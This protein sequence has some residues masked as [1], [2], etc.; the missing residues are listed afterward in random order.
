MIISIILPICNNQT[1]TPNN[2]FINQLANYRVQVT[3][4]TPIIA[5]GSVVLINFPRQFSPYQFQIN[6][7]YS[8][9]AA[10]DSC[11]NAIG[12]CTAVT[13]DCSGQTIILNNLY[14]NPGT[15]A[16]TYTIFNIR[17]PLYKITTSSYTIEIRSPDYV[18][19]L[20]RQPVTGR[21]FFAEQFT[22]ITATLNN[23][24]LWQNSDVTFDVTVQPQ[25]DY[26]RLT[27]PTIRWEN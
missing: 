17:N 8:G 13:I 22:S 21:N 1:I 5:A 27:F 10:T 15:P 12:G 24:Y 7:P 25:M 3:N 11:P 18:N 19:T 9:R 16:F 26:F 20:Y 23:P 6:K 14:G 2:I 4:A